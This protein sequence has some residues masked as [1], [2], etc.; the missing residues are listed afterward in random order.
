MLQTVSVFARAHSL[1][2]PLDNML[3]HKLLGSP[4]LFDLIFLELLIL[5]FELKVIS[6]VRFDPDFL[7]PPPSSLLVFLL[8]MPLLQSDL[9]SNFTIQVPLLHLLLLFLFLLLLSSLL[10]DLLHLSLFLLLPQLLGHFHLTLLIQSIL[11]IS[12][13]LFLSSSLSL[14]FVQLF[15]ALVHFCFGY[16]SF[17]SEGCLGFSS[18]CLFTL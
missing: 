16:F 2:E 17:L 6:S 12:F 10:L 11:R 18:H 13:F 14:S 7:H 4:L 15:D 8:L 5:V 3:Y 9:L 1:I